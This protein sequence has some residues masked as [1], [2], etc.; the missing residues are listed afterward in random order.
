MLLLKNKKFVENMSLD[1]LLS[2]TVPG[3]DVFLVQDVSDSCVGSSDTT[4]VSD[5]SFSTC[6]YILIVCDNSAFEEA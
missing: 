5:V 6:Q 2:P 3:D 1:K 4:A